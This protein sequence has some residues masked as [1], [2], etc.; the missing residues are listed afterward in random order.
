[1]ETYIA[2]N[3]TEEEVNFFNAKFTRKGCVRGWGKE[4]SHIYYT[5]NNLPKQNAPDGGWVVKGR[6]FRLVGKQLR[7]C[8]LCVDNK[9]YIPEDW[10]RC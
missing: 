1:M 6:Y 4:P 10:G 3:L 8:I 5:I 7:Q 2:K 9:T